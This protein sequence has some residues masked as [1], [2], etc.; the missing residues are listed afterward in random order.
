MP[1][2]NGPPFFPRPAKNGGLATVM[3]I[4]DYF[5]AHAPHP[6]D[7]VL[8]GF[9]DH[10]QRLAVLRAC[11]QGAYLWADAMLQAREAKR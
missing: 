4:R 1:L 5:A 10:E 8:G 7:G 11:A 6:G 3:S 2:D 9:V